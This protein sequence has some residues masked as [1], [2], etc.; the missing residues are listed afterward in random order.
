MHIEMA[1]YSTNLFP[2][3]DTQL[4]GILGIG[5][6][7]FSAPGTSRILGIWLLFILQLL[8]T[9]YFC[10]HSRLWSRFIFSPS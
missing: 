4:I 2:T 1:F 8:S 9:L 3:I 7:V 6:S 5:T 10:L